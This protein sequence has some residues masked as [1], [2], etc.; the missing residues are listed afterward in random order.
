MRNQSWCLG[1]GSALTQGHTA[2][3]TR[4]C[5][6]RG[7]ASQ[8]FPFPQDHCLVQ[9]CTRDTAGHNRIALR[10]FLSELLFR[11]F[12]LLDLLNWEHR[13]LALKKPRMQLWEF[14][15]AGIQGTVLMIL[16]KSLDPVMSEADSI[17][18]PFF[19]YHALWSS[20]FSCC[21]PRTIY[22]TSRSKNSHRF[23]HLSS[24]SFL[25]DSG[26][27]ETS[28]ETIRIYDPVSHYFH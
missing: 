14:H 18:S 24:R 3:I 27:N 22:P 8:S 26:A 25:P 4:L 23:Q 11:L 28:R 21:H 1:W 13:R 17:N 19:S 9:R 20:R 7:H 10:S 12:F 5:R 2:I 16:F 6:R 15:R